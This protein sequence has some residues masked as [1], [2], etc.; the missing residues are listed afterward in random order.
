MDPSATMAHR[1]RKHKRRIIENYSTREIDRSIDW[2]HSSNSYI[3]VAFN[4]RKDFDG[5][6]WRMLG[7][8][9]LSAR[10]AL[11]GNIRTFCEEAPK[12]KE[13]ITKKGAATAG[14]RRSGKH[15]NLRRKKGGTNLGRVLG[16]VRSNTFDM[17]IV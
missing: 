14:L 10:F 12:A 4:R 13:E 6:A 16:I 15:A 1:S 7:S 9:L 2:C 5:K 17:W 3:P 11:R 8:R